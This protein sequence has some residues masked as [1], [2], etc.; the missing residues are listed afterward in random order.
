MAGPRRRLGVI[1]AVGVAALFLG[2]WG[3]VFLTERLWEARVSEAAAVVGT[4][5]ALYRVGVES[6]GIIIAC[7]WFVFNFLAANRIARTAEP[8]GSPSLAQLLPEPTRRLVLI[9]LGMLLGIAIG[10][11]SRGWLDLIL[12]SARGVH[13][14]APDPLLGEDLGVFVAQ[15]PL[16][17][18]LQDWFLALALLAILGVMFI[19]GLGG[20][21]RIARRRPR[22]APRA[23][24]QFAILLAILAIV[25][26]WGYALDPI[27]L[28]AERAG[29]LGP[30][31]FLFRSSVSQLLAV[32]AAGVAVATFLWGFRAKAVWALAAWIVLGVAVVAGQML[33]SS[34]GGDGLP[35]TPQ[36]RILRSVDSAAFAIHL[37]PA[38]TGQPQRPPLVSLWDAETLERA[39]AT[40]SARAIYIQPGLVRVG[41]DSVPVWFLLR[42]TL[43]FGMHLVAIADDRTG[44]TGGPMSLRWGD[45]LFTPGLVPFYQL[46]PHAAR[47]GFDDLDVDAAARGVPLWSAARRLA[48]GW[49]LQSS[50]VLRGQSVDRVGWRLDPNDRLAAIA[51]FAEWGAPRIRFVAGEL[52]WELDGFLS[53]DRFPASRTVQWRGHPASMVRP[54]F[55]GLVDARSGG[56]RLFL[57][58]DS[59]SLAHAWADLA[60]PLIEDADQIPGAVRDGR[61]YPSDLL[62]VQAQVLEGEPWLG[63]PLAKVGRIGY[64][65]GELASRGTIGDPVTIP[66]M[67]ESGPLVATLVQAM[68]TP[69]GLLQTAADIDS[70]RATGGA[71]DLEQKWERFDF[72]QKLRDSVR[73]A[74]S[75]LTHGLVRY[76]LLG[77]TVAAYQPSYAIGPSGR[78]TVALVTAA[79]GARLGYGRTNAEAWRNLRGDVGPAPVGR[80]VASRLADARRWLERADSALKRGDLLEFGRAFAYLRELL[81]STD[82]K[83]E[84]PR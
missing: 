51:P 78:V 14:G 73:A 9:A 46:G 27:Q 38:P 40:D 83:P 71:R 70:T 29:A 65:V 64:P 30:A 61:S 37:V 45:S 59:D 4:R 16:W 8:A 28:A 84:P 19:H 2:R 17:Q 23:R 32:L 79:L 10:P 54:A 82:P 7:V 76:Q 49:A 1:L 34:R 56:A 81:Q 3:A 11:I 50:R 25:L 43:H 72:Y 26:A 13:Y 62:A 60:R 22:L 6:I 58:Q 80:E 53:S 24:W 5:W 48:L 41:A 57:R 39:A 18:A 20:T 77:D 42:Q 31:E 15:L 67:M 63:R 35:G 66:F 44:P 36:R 12:L 47:P 33:V 74:G 55:V 68:S 52:F 69:D 75:D 21:L